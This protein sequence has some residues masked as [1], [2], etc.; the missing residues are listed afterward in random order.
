[1]EYYESLGIY[2]LREYARD[3]GVKSPTMLRKSELIKEIELIKTGQKMP[4]KKGGRKSK[5]CSI[6][7]LNIKKCENCKIALE[8]EQLKEKINK[9]KKIL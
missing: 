8:L 2:L 1:M 4:H 9:I 6:G 3:V 5:Y 7:L